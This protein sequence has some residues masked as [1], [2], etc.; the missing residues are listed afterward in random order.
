MIYIQ[1][2]AETEKDLARLG[3][4]L[5]EDDHLITL[6]CGEEEKTFS[7]LGVNARTLLRTAK[8]MAQ[9]REND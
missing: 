4:E 9:R 2:W 1:T 8:E 6:R 7:A 5:I 3:V